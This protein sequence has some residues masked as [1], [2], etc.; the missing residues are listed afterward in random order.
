MKSAGFE[1]WNFSFE[2]GAVTSESLMLATWT[3]GFITYTLSHVSGDFMYRNG[4]KK[5]LKI[6]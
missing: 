2:T 3:Q 5:T 4:H 1:H 6:V